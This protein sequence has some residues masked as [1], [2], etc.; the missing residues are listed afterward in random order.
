MDERDQLLIEMSVASGGR[1]P[2][3]KIVEELRKRLSHV[4]SEIAQQSD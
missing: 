3:R 2:N 4:Q 1:T